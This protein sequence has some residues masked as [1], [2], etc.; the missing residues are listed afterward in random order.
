MDREAPKRARVMPATFSVMAS[1]WQPTA[2]KDLALGLISFS[3]A[4]TEILFLN[5]DYQFHEKLN[6]G[7]MDGCDFLQQASWDEIQRRRNGNLGA[8]A[9]R[10]IWAVKHPER[11]LC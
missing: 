1:K 7:W 10:R 5:L 3:F 6:A 9:I 11:R 8:S 4:A 2:L